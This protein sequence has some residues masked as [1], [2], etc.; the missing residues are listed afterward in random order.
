MGWSGQVLQMGVTLGATGLEYCNS[1]DARADMI[2]SY[3][4][5]ITGDVQNCPVSPTSPGDSLAL[6]ALYNNTD[7]PNWSNNSNWLSGYVETWHGVIVS[8]GRVIDVILNDNALSGVI[9][10]EI[11]DLTALESLQLYNNSLS[12]SIPAE[13]GNLSS[14]TIL[15]LQNNALSGEIP[16][17]IGGIGSLMELKLLLINYPEVSLRSWEDCPTSL[18]WV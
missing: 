16:V 2:S 9:P 11:G 7:G 17:A 18:F 5:T 1:T 12:G 3:G 8:E 14:L 13:I 15:S 4:W 10:S 6:V